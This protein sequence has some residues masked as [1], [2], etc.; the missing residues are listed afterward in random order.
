MKNLEGTI[1]EN[2][3]LALVKTRKTQTETAIALGIGKSKMSDVLAGRAELS[4]L[5]LYAASRF[6]GVTTDWFAE[7][8]LSE[9]VSA[10]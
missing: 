1:A 4:A 3:K 2:L 9:V 8:H 6:F 5:E 7:E 10:A